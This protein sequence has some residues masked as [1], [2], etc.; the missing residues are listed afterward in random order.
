MYSAGEDSLFIS[1][2]LKHKLKIYAYPEKIATVRQFES[3]WFK[4]Y[5][6][7]YF[8]DKGALFYA[9]NHKLCGLL[10]LQDYIRHRGLYDESALNA[11]TILDLERK[12]A[13]GYRKLEPYTEN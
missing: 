10:L 11:T 8:Y 5:T 4:C 6:K 13:K 9:L 3:S 1:D 2:L 12:G 7:K